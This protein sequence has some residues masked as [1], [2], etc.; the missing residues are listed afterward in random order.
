[1]NIRKLHISMIVLTV[2][3]LIALPVRADRDGDGAPRF[4]DR[5]ITTDRTWA[6]DVIKEKERQYLVS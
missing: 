2:C 1:M 6:R 4:R 5:I 3:G